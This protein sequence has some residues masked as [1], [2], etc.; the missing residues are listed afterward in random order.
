MPKYKRYLTKRRQSYEYRFQRK[1]GTYFWV[2]DEMKMVR[3]GE[4]KPLEIIG[5]WADITERKRLESLLEK[6]RQE[7]KLIIDTSPIIIFYKDKEGRFIRVN[8]AFAEALKMPE[9]DFVGKTVFDLYSAKIAQGMTNDDHEVLKSVRPKLNIIEQYESASGIRWVQTDKIPICDKNGIPLGLIGFAQDITERKQAEEALRESEANLSALI[10]NTNDWICSL[11]S[12]GRILTMNKAFKKMFHLFVKIEMQEGMN[13]MEY[14]SPE[15]RTF[16]ADIHDRALKGEHIFFEGRYGPEGI[17][18]NAE[19]SVNPIIGGHGEITGAS[20]FARDITERKRAEE[21]LW[22]SQELYRSLFE[23][24]PIGL[25]RTMPSGEILDTNSALVEILGY[26]DRE[27]LLVV[28]LIDMFV[29]PDERKRWEALMES[30]GIVHDF[31]AQFRRYD[32]TVIW[33][34]NTCHA[35]RHD[36]GQTLY[37]EGAIQDITE[38]KKAEEALRESEEKYRTILETIEEGYY[39]VDL[40]GNFTFINDSMCQIF[41]YSKEELIGMNDRQYTD[42]K[43][44]KKLFQAYHT[45]YKTGEPSRRFEF[46]IIRKDRSKSYVEASI[47]LRKDSLTKPIG[48]SG[49]IR[50]ITERKRAEEATEGE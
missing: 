12:K 7:L 31:E 32:G 45:V 15:H 25:Y 6:E 18:V 43:T 13:I 35:A 42:Q 11:D 33:I 29:N 10:E 28:N 1:D 38:R 34:R 48:F 8:K 17:S 44:A 19:V 49:I 5:Y 41:G 9:E 4:G 23:G 47:S 2:R 21:T 50:D 46:E 26:P 40:A 20:Y 36:D 39:E 27:S 16:W 22:E 14:M 30:Q 3:D 37:H 24:V